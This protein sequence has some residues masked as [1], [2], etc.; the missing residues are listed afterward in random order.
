MA[1]FSINV[2]LNG[3]D[4]AVSTVGQLEDAL[5]ATKD[6]LKNIEVGSDAFEELTKQARTLQNELKDVKEAT[7][8]DKNLGQLGESVG[9]LGSTVASGFA[10][11]TSALSLFG[12]ES[13]DITKAQVAAQNALAIA[14]SATTIAANAQKFTEDARNVGLVIQNGLVATL[15]ALTSAQTTATGAA[16][17]AQR[18]LNAVMAANPIGLLVAAIGTLV[19]AIYLFTDSEEEA[20]VAVKDYNAEI[21]RQT[22]AITDNIEK[23]IKLLEINARVQSIGK[24]EAERL[25]I[26]AQLIRDVGKAQEESLKTQVKAVDAKLEL[27]RLEL[28]ANAERS[29][30]SERLKA[31]QD[32][33][34]SIMKL[35][36]KGLISTDEYYNKLLDIRS[37]YFV[38]SEKLDKKGFEEQV[39][40]YRNLLNE[41]KKLNDQLEVLAAE[42]AAKEKEKADEITNNEKEAL[43]KRR[44]AYKSFVDDVGK[45]TEERAKAEEDL[46]RELE[47]FWLDR[48]SLIRGEDGVLR[49]DLIA[50]YDETIKKLG[51]GRDR[52]LEDAKKAFEAELKA[53]EEN[54][55]KKLDANGKRLI[56]DK[57]I[58]DAINSQR[59]IFNK[60][61]VERA[62]VFNEQILISEQD[63][64]DKIREIDEIL[65][66]EIAFGDNALNDSQ[67]A[68]KLQ[69]FQFDLNIKNQQ[70]ASERGYN[71]RL[72]KK[73]ANLIKDQI[74]AQQEADLERAK[75]DFD[76]AIKN[77]QGTEKQNGL[78]RTR[79]TEKYNVDVAN[80]NERFRQNDLAAD[81]A[82]IDE[83]IAYRV[84]KLQEYSN[85][86]FQAA[87]SVVNIVSAVNDGARQEEEQKINEQYSKEQDA[88][89]KSL[90]SGLI[91]RKE[92]DKQNEN[93]RKR[94]EAAEY[95]AKKE[96]FEQDKKLRIAQAIIAGA[97]GALS[98]FAGAM[99]LGPIAGPIVG[100]ILA[101]LVVAATGVQVANIKKQ[102][103]DG[104][105][106]PV[107]PIDGDAGGAVDTGAAAVQQASGGGFT[108]F[109]PNLTNPGGQTPGGTPTGSGPT[110]VYVL[111]SD[112]TDTQ[113]RVRAY[114]TNATF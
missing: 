106:V 23:K 11:A 37:K 63:K 83:L 54:E 66:T 74:K 10:A 15:T 51:V 80:I 93:L 33:T 60:E 112:I 24:T 104:G 64:A 62:Q 28:L 59:D 3:V 85:F 100:G 101:A 21:D 18:T 65:K 95:K 75:I 38:E 69:Q 110:K 107:T 1:D 35:R 52:S 45:L 47:D 88:L 30:D 26:E 61:Q 108:G 7:N 14:L 19:G 40:D 78:E 22:K 94:R 43:N 31:E 42:K 41:S 13:E 53:F 111:E 8:F 99:Q 27:S 9:R 46:Y 77:V 91:T 4:Q 90:N 87:D 73:R 39:N 29:G 71:E 102:K 49:E 98:A 109:T 103:F 79:L 17:V 32:E 67:K 81:K 58:N 25:K 86:A 70:I 96:A 16:T 92:Y 113:N 5:K 50:S 76:N 105:A 68:L 36:D 12:E 48:I 20:T 97:Q 72:L 55:K 56:S 84:Q 89:N 44:D 2:K 34:V 57:Q 82:A 114:E 6:E